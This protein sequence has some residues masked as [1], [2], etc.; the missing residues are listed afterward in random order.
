MN[1]PAIHGGPA[2]ARAAE[3]VV[4]GLRRLAG[5][6]PERAKAA[7]LG[8]GTIAVEVGRVL[9]TPDRVL[10]GAGCATTVEAYWEELR[11][12]IESELAADV[13]R[14]LEVEASCTAWEM[15]A[16]ADSLLVVFDVS[17]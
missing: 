17:R 13:G 4:C 16:T 8:D 5:R 12:A 11:K 6:G 1:D 3:A 15:D 2:R 10:T 7:F 14:A 9:T